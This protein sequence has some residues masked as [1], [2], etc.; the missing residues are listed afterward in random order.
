MIIIKTP[1]EIERMRESGR[2]VALA[3]EAVRRAVAPGVTTAELDAIAERVILEEG[4]VPSFKGYNGFSGSICTSVNEEVIHGIP[5]SRRLKEG[6]IISVDI[7]AYKNGFHGDAARTHAVGVVSDAA[8][9]LIDVTRE[10][11][12][13]GM[14]ACKPGNRLSDISHAVQ[15][16]AESYGYG[17]VRI[18]EGHG[19]GRDLHEDPPVPNYGRP[20]RGPRLQSG[21]VIAIEPMITE[22]TYDVTILEDEWTVVTNDGRLSAHHEQTIVI[23]EDGAEI[24]TYCEEEVENGSR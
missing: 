21:M 10:S 11:F 8:R 15:E 3:H 7:G 5:G 4:A 1:E 17:V 19:V 9:Q 16:H 23:T 6:D 24:L 20:G 2:I 18:F 12:Y 22:G 14:R 13:A